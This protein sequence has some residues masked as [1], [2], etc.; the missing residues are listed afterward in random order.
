MDEHTTQSEGFRISKPDPLLQR[1]QRI[2]RGTAT[3]QDQF[4]PDHEELVRLLD[5]LRSMN[6]AIAFTTGVW[7]GLHIGHTGYLRN[8]KLEA[9]RR[10]EEKDVDHVIMV[11]GV[12]SDELTRI[13]KP[14]LNRPLVPEDER[15]QMLSDTRWV[16]IITM[17]YKAD[18]LYRIVCADLRIISQTTGDLPDEEEMRK[19]CGELIRL[20]PQAQ[21]SSTARIQKLAA[22]GAG[23][24][25]D[26]VIRTIE[27]FF[28]EATS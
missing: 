20:P 22:E 8:G 15:C 18:T 26:R 10:L 28:R 4:V 12:E 5:L 7:D 19:Y 16:D 17:Q 23:Q 27:D 11:V 14:G 9:M 6:C 1:A 2:L 24:L 21:T 13:R 3:F 25:R